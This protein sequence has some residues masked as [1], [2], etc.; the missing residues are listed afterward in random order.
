MAKRFTDTQ[1]WDDEWF[2]N[3]SNDNK[4]VWLYLLDNV[5][6]AGLMKINIRSLN[7]KCRT[8]HT[9]ETIKELLGNRLI[10]VREQYIFIPKFI[11]FQYNSGLNSDKP[12]IVSVVKELTEFNLLD[13][14]RELFGNDY[15][16]IKD[17]YKD[18]SIKST[19][20]VKEYAIPKDF[21]KSQI[22]TQLSEINMKSGLS[23]SEFEE[24]LTQWSLSCEKEGWEYSDNPDKDLRRLQAGFQKWANTWVSNK[25]KEKPRQEEFVDDFHARR[26]AEV[27]A[28]REREA[29]K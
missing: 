26:T 28:K 27:L 23:P 7:F 15:A 14:I 9:L 3:L 18:K 4:V 11:K 1:K 29:N 10:I 24:C 25:R 22:E 12:V 5:N 8:E 2:D 13:K 16:I 19:E 17:I 20:E 6:H 21:L